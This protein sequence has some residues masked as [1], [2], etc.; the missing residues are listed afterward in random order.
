[1]LTETGQTSP[2]TA[3]FLI[4]TVYFESQGRI[5]RCQP[6]FQGSYLDALDLAPLAPLAQVELDHLTFH[7][8]L[9]K[10]LTQVLLGNV[11]CTSMVPE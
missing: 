5:L 8:P 11:T 9:T 7:F 10:S 3:D 4:N 1:M 2:L 6:T